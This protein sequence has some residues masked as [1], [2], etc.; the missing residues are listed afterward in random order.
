MAV[1]VALYQLERGR[2]YVRETP[3]RCAS[4]KVPVM[5]QLLQMKR[6]MRGRGER[7]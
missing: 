6:G 5:R 2:R 3:P 4:F 7:L 1:A